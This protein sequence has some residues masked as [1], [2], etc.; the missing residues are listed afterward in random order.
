M[1]GKS[2]KLHQGGLDWVFREIFLQKGCSG[3]ECPEHLDHHSQKSS[4]KMCVALGDLALLTVR[5]HDRKDLFQPQRFCEDG[6]QG[7]SSSSSYLDIFSHSSCVFQTFCLSFCF[8]TFSLHVHI[9]CATAWTFWSGDHTLETTS[10]T[11]EN[12]LLSACSVA[13]FRGIISIYP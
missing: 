7:N 6:S 2:L 9:N 10:V 4:Q 3:T 11:K 5:L 8:L 12:C 13:F 1:R